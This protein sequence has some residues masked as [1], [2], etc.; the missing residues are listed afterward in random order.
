MVMIPLGYQEGDSKTENLS[1]IRLHNLYLTENRYSPD[2]LS[3]LTRPTTNRVLTL[4]NQAIYGFFRQA[5]TIN[6][7]WFIVAGEKLFVVNPVDMTVHFE[8][9]LPGTEIC[10]FA[11]TED[12]VVIVRNGIAYSTDGSSIYT[13]TMPDNVPVGSVATIDGSFL[14][15]VLGQQKYYWMWPG[16]TDPD[17]LNFA[18]AERTPDSLVSI[19]VIFDEVWFLGASGVEVWQTTGDTDLPYQRISGRVYSESCATSAAVYEGTA[20]GLPCLIWVTAKK[21]VVMAQGSPSRISTKA[22]EKEI[23]FDTNF[24]SWG[25][26]WNM[27]DFY[28]LTS[29]QRTLVYDITSGMWAKWDTYLQPNWKAHLG[30]QVNERV[31]AGDTE[32]GVICEFEDGYLDDG[33]IPVV[34]EVSGFVLSMDA[35]VECYSVNVRMNVGWAPEYDQLP[36]IEMRWSDDYGFSW[37]EYFPANIGRKGN[38]DFDATWRSL[39]SY[40]RPGREF[41]FRF[42]DPAKF[43]IDYATMNEV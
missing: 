30:I 16:E 24:R 11:G 3:R 1:R 8:A 25:F 37:T 35:G 26:R 43:R 42:S 2:S 6:D 38:Y 34:R 41:E 36:V 4:S 17:S 13:I 20:N 10:T 22:V 21:S 9:S 12:K 23:R 28:V 19:N 31:F 33:G 27:H 39:G 14:L 15:G 32:A 5:G 18:S 40:E 29:D 7:F